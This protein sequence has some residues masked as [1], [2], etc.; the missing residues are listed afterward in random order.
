MSTQTNEARAAEVRAAAAL[1][2][3]CSRRK[4]VAKLTQECGVEAEA[5]WTF[6]TRAKSAWT[7]AEWDAQL[8]QLDALHIPVR[9]WVASFG[10]EPSPSSESKR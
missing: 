10:Y 8:A 1:L 6:A 5:L 2:S 7:K 9:D 3:Q 4:T